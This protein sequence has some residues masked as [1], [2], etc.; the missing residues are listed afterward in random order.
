MAIVTR[1]YIEATY[2]RLKIIHRF[3]TLL[4]YLT[5]SPS[6]L[7]SFTSIFLLLSTQPIMHPTGQESIKVFILDWDGPWINRVFHRVKLGN[8]VFFTLQ[9]D[10]IKCNGR[11]DTPFSFVYSTIRVC[12]LINKEPSSVWQEI[13][14]DIPLWSDQARK[15]TMLLICTRVKDHFVAFEEAIVW[16]DWTNATPGS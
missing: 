14:I 16:H 1:P 12:I 15:F 9:R 7:S 6:L 5:H 10:K 11:D 8:F 3:L 2:S 13:T 4:R